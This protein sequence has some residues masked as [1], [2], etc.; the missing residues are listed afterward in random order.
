MNF[1]GLLI[2][3]LLAGIGNYLAERFV[4]K[5]PNDPHDTGIVDQAPGLGMDDLA[6]ATT[7]GLTVILGG[8][9]ARKFLGGKAA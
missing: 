4:I 7:I 6:R 1:K 8:S 2:V 9:L 5:D 3:I